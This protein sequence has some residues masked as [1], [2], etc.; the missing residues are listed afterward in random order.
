VAFRRTFSSGF[1]VE[2]FAD[3]LAAAAGID[4]LKFRLQLI[5]ADRKIP[6]FTNPKENNRWIP[7]ASRVFC[8]SLLKKLSGASPPKGRRRGIA[9]YFSFESYTAAVAEA[10]VEKG[11]VRIHRIVYA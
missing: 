6:D 3:E 10:S 1:V 5:G 4:P 7:R 2:T 11:Q 8:N 9:G